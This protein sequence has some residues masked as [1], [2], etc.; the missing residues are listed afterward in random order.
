MNKKHKLIIG[1]CSFL[2]VFFAGLFVNG[3]L[4]LSG[5]DEIYRNAL[6]SRY[7]IQGEEITTKVESS[8]NLGKKLYLLDNQVKPLF[9]KAMADIPEIEHLY[10]TDSNEKI[11][12]T[13]RAVLKQDHIPFKYYDG[14]APTEGKLYYTHKFLDSWFA[15]MPFYSGEGGFEG[16]LY[17]E[18]S[19]NTISEFTGTYFSET[20]K[21][22]IILFIAG[23]LIY[24]IFSLFFMKSKR[25]ETILTIVLML[26]S[27]IPFSFYSYKTFNKAITQVF[28][29]NMSVLS[30]SIVSSLNNTGNVVNGFSA[31][32]GMDEYLETRLQGNEHCASISILGESS[33]VL[34]SSSINGEPINLNLENPDFLL[35]D[36]KFGNKKAT[37]VLQINRTLINEILR[38]MAVDSA[39]II[40]VAL[41]FAFILKDL[42][43]LISQKRDLLVRPEKMSAEEASTALKLIK[44]STFIF[45]FAAFETVSFIP[46]YIQDIYEKSID[47]LGF[48]SSMHQDTVISLPVGSY[49]FG[50][51]VSM[52]ITLFVIKKLA[53]KYRYV[54]MSLIF[55][56]GSLLTMWADNMFMLIIARLV[57]GFGFG[58]V[59]LSTS[60]LVIAYT[61][62]KTRSAG[63]G[64][65]AAGFAAASIASIPVGGVLVSKFGYDA[66]LMTSVVFAILFLLFSIFCVP[67]PKTMNKEESTDDIVLEEPITVKQFG[68][69]LRAPSIWAYIICINLPFQLIYWGLFQF[70]L[71]IYMN[72][73][74]H[75]SQSNIGL[76]LSIFSF[77]SLGAAM[78]GQMA[79]K[80]KNDK[81]LIGIGALLAGS[82]LVAFGFMKESIIFFV[83]VVSHWECMGRCLELSVQ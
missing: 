61:S 41:I 35:R 50:I 59:L 64:T 70:L 1:I 6:M 76:I 8:L 80:I 16:T 30:D 78:A 25:A 12:Y 49:M 62:T 42:F 32:S 19:Q 60:S 52:F 20:I 58:G 79:D 28:N 73:T 2:I 72:D 47:S 71:P 22:G 29:T 37:L 63:F 10:I 17:I 69:V 55:V 11:L 18:I 14:N 43:T 15:C 77:V 81:F 57:A 66:G 51:M 68:K 36:F 67:N 45:M 82:S 83:V 56:A 27:L 9:N 26:G 54:L 3:M 7:S 24:V 38:D 34:Y 5:F 23:F 65:N 40:V 31:I 46:L 13:T 74:L 39:V 21:Y 48:L 44:I 75:L 4:G 53:V 33:E